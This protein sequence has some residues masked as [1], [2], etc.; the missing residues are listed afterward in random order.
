MEPDIN[1]SLAAVRYHIGEG[2]FC[3]DKLYLTVLIS[4]AFRKSAYSQ[5]FHK[6]SQHTKQDKTRSFDVPAYVLRSTMQGQLWKEGN[7]DYHAALNVGV[8]LIYGMQ[9]ELVQLDDEKWMNEV[10]DDCLMYRLV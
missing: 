9:D 1:T 10:G 7:E 3:A 2:P 5:A 8:L 4:V 6:N